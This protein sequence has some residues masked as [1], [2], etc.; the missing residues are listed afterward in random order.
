LADANGAPI[1]NTVNMVFRLYGAASGG[2]PL[3]E[4]QWTGS[5]AVQVSDGLFN[6][7]LGSLTPI[8]QSVITGN[9]NLFLGITVG[10]DD[11][12]TPR[13]QLGSVPFAV[14]A[15]TVPDGSITKAKLGADVNLVPPTESI[16]TTMIMNGAVTASKLKLQTGSICQSDSTVSFALTGS[17]TRVPIPTMSTSFTLD[18]VGNVLIWSS[19]QYTYAPSDGGHTGTTIYLDGTEIRNTSHIPTSG[20]NDFTMVTQIQIP[21][22]T[23]ILDLRAYAVGTGTATY[24]ETCIEFVVLG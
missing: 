16:T 22:G 6:V 19:G 13:V 17:Y 15:L 5:N 7:M 2:A 1:T 23:H 10:T 18:H 24:T 4:E 9:S 11:E 12:M 3:W 20:W 8:P 21:E 14:Q